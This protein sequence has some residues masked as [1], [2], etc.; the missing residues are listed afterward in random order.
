MLKE[1]KSDE[2]KIFD[3]GFSN[4]HK[5][6]E[7]NIKTKDVFIKT[8]IV[9]VLKQYSAVGKN[10]S[11]INIDGKQMAKISPKCSFLAGLTITAIPTKAKY[12]KN[13]KTRRFKNLMIYEALFTSL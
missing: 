11:Q 9:L 13:G 6:R 1:P 8:P 3:P 2:F 7:E 10:L 4:I 5:L 12:V